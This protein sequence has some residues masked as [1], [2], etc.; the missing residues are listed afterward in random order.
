MPLNLYGW[1]KHLFDQYVLKMSK[2]KKSSPPFW[3]GFKFF[4]VYG[5][6]EYHKGKMKSVVATIFPKVK[7]MKQLIYLNLTTPNI[8]MES[9]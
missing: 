8:K 6:N 4:N 5:P 2:E 3:S 9:K 1:S 7:K